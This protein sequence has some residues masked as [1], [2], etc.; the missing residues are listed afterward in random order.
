MTPL[1]TYFQ[2]IPSC[3]P[4]AYAGLHPV[5]GLSYFL[6]QVPLQNGRPRV[7]AGSADI[8]G[9]VGGWGI[10]RRKLEFIDLVVAHKVSL[11]G[12]VTAEPQLDPNLEG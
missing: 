9:P 10:H 8:G 12:K 4:Q 7:E 5:D 3:E 1:N 11:I 6:H 2:H